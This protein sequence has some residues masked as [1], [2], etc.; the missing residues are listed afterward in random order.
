MTVA[1]LIEL[2]QKEKPYLVVQ[3]WDSRKDRFTER[4]YVQSSNF[5]SELLI[6][7][8]EGPARQP[9]QPEWPTLFDEPPGR[10]GGSAR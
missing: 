8:A 4:F 2:L 1:E 6:T 3:L 9:S 10:G 7:P 5:D